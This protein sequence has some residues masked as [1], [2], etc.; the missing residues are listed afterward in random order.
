MYAKLSHHL[1]MYLT[2]I[3]NVYYVWGTVLDPENGKI[4]PCSLE[5]YSWMKLYFPN[6]YFPTCCPC[7]IRALCQLWSTKREQLTLDKG[8][9]MVRESFEGNYVWDEP[10]ALLIDTTFFF[11][12]TPWNKANKPKALFFFFW[13]KSLFSLY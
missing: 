9:G 8:E 4:G 3:L 11:N 1:F 5:D 13:E 12:L 2:K 7:H 6:K 10:G